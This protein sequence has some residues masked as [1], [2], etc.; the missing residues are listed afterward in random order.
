M[1]EK[2]KQQSILDKIEKHSMLPAFLL[3]V[4]FTIFMFLR[5]NQEKKEICENILNQQFVL[6]NTKKILK[7]MNAENLAD[8]TVEKIILECKRQFKDKNTLLDKAKEQAQKGSFMA[9]EILKNSSP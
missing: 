8:L 5:D 7:T 9:K 3:A 6:N 2:P 4:A 1:S